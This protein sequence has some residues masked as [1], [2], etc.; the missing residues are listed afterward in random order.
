M[1]FPATLAAPPLAARISA[2]HLACQE[3]AQ[4]QPVP[5]I[6]PLWEKEAW[7]MC[8]SDLWGNLLQLCET[9]L[10]CAAAAPSSLR[11]EAAVGPSCS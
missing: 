8:C 2:L 7:E 6:V 11:P 5:S 3:R 9:H 1:E 4:A 10:T